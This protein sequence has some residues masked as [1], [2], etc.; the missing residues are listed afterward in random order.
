MAEESMG[1]E[2][3]KRKWHLNDAKNDVQHLKREL[4]RL[5]DWAQRG[6]DAAEQIPD[7][8]AKLDITEARLSAE[9]RATARLDIPALKVELNRL[10]MDIAHNHTAKSERRIFEIICAAR[11][12]G[13]CGQDHMRYVSTLGRIKTGALP[14]STLVDWVHVPQTE[15]AA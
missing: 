1:N 7:T 14:W 15:K 9:S 13:A 3:T 8:R 6:R 2:K 4:A 12:A 10:C 5:K 11:A